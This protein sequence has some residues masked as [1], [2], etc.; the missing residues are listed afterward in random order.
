[1]GV[2]APEVC[3]KRQ[4][5]ARWRRVR[6]CSAVS[7]SKMPGTR[8]MT[9]VTIAAAMM[10]PKM[11][12]VAFVVLLKDADHAWLT[13]FTSKRPWGG[14]ACPGFVRRICESRGGSAT[15]LHAGAS[16][17]YKNQR[18]R[19]IIRRW[20]KRSNRR[21]LVRRGLQEK[22]LPE[23][24]SPYQCELMDVSGRNRGA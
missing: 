23:S 3:P 15:L 14:L 16:F 19:G 9:M 4:E 12:L 17:R 20:M 6:R 18:P 13:T 22:G 10:R 21:G 1:M 8:V 7:S 11:I 24:R 2:L 5:C